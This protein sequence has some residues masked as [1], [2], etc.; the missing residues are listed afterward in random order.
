MNDYTKNDLEEARR[1]ISSLISKCEKVQM[2]LREGTPQYALTRNRIKAF[3]I[4]LSLIN[5]ELE[6]EL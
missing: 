2:K 4:V 5:K 6:S 3:N 1:A